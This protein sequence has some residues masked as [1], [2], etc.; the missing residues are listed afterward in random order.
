MAIT[1]HRGP[2]AGR[3]AVLPGAVL[4]HRRLSIIDLTGENETTVLV[5]GAGAEGLAVSPDGSEVWVANRRDQSVAVVDVRRRRI[6]E[7]IASAAFVGRAE[8]SA[9]GRVLVPNGSFGGERA[10]QQLTLYDQSSRQQI[11]RHRVRAAQDNTGGF[12]IHIVDEFAFVSDRTSG[13]IELYDLANFPAS[14]VLFADH[15]YP[16]GMA[17]SPLRMNSVTQ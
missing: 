17:F 2:E 7:N 5:T 1:S 13:A 8:I 14:T 12:N 11:A 3:L 9:G 16:D 6:A 15:D 10:P 4:G